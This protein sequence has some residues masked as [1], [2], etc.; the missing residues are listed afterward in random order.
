[1]F[2]LL[3]K[4]SH[5]LAPQSTEFNS[6]LAVRSQAAL[7]G[8]S[9]DKLEFWDSP[10]AI[11]LSLRGE[12]GDFLD[13]DSWANDPAKGHVIFVHGLCESDI[14]WQ[15]GEHHQQFYHELAQSGY[16]VAWLR[17][18]T[19]RAIHHN[20]EEFAE[21]LQNHFAN[22]GKSVMLI[23]HSM[24]GL[25][26][27]SAMDW[28]EKQQHTWLSRISHAAYLGT[29]HLGAPLERLGNKANNLLNITPY[30]RPFMRLGN[31][32]SRGIKDLRYARIT[33]DNIVP[34]LPEHIEHLLVASTW[35]SEY[36]YDVVG[37]G[38]VPMSSALAQDDQGDVLFAPKVTRV[39]LNDMSHIAM[40]SDERIYQQLRQWLKLFV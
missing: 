22:K 1:A 23:G 9:G 20:G 27:R 19:G 5:I 24:G 25:V 11:S 35:K 28:A 37:D 32:R 8:V 21:L 39:T 3:A 4:L 15:R 31:I 18:N 33:E 34:H 12:H 40:L 30:T 17:Y 2:S 29:P 7:N 16:K 10:L 26:I 13:L 14:D 38:L 6:P 36:D